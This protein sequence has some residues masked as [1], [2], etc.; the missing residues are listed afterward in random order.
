MQVDIHIHEGPLPSPIPWHPD[1]AGAV[2][3]FEGIVR[4]SEENRPLAA[5]KYQVYEP[6]TT[7]ELRRLAEAI[8]R[9]YP[10]LAMRIEHSHGMVSAGQCSFRLHVA[11]A[12][13]AEALAAMDPF[14]TRMKQ[15][16]PIWKLPVWA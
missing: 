11:A 3:V 2:V 5:L 10:L 7:R 15:Q 1:G 6:M 8:G 14:I 12:H 13:R 9:E 4:P 16:V